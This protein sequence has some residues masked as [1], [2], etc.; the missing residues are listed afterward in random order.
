MCI[1]SIFL[2]RNIAFQDTLVP[3]MQII[4]VK[5]IRIIRKLYPLQ[6]VRIFEW[7]ATYH[8]F[9]KAIIE[10][11]D[12]LTLGELMGLPTQDPDYIPFDMNEDELNSIAFLITSPVSYFYYKFSKRE[13][14]AR[15]VYW[16]NKNRKKYERFD[17]IMSL[18]NIAAV[19]ELSGIE[20]QEFRAFLF[21][22][23]VCDFK[24]SELQIYSEVHGLWDVYQEL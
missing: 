12:Q 23:M 10:M 2:V 1:R 8:D 4:E 9:T 14:S 3:V 5:Y 17:A 20:L 11:P 19:T 18:E 13:K 22:R 15:K 24:C 6:E 16:L 21:K 7:G